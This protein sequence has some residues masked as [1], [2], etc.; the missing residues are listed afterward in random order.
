VFRIY[1]MRN[2]LCCVSEVSEGVVWNEGVR[3]VPLLHTNSL[4]VC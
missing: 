2:M 1:I 4:V 3:I